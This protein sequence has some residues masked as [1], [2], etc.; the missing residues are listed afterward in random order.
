MR[1]VCVAEEEEHVALADRAREEDGRS[2][3]EE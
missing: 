1:M 3:E 2:R